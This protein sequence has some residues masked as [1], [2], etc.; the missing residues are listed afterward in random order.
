MKLMIIEMPSAKQ[1][2]QPFTWLVSPLNETAALHSGLKNSISM[3]GFIG[4]LDIYGF[5]VF[6]KNS[7]EQLCINYVNENFQ[8]TSINT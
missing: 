4:V 3:A 5:E 6:E 8:D 2:T 1:F 7:F